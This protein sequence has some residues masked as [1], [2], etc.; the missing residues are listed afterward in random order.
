M[1]NHTSKEEPM[2][3]ARAIRTRRMVR[4]FDGSDL[5]EGVVRSLFDDGLRA[6]TAGNARGVHFVILMGTNETSR[7]FDSATDETWRATARRAPGLQRASAVGVCVVDPSRYVGRYGEADKAPS[8]LGGG[9]DRWPVPYWFGDAGAATMA[10]L[11]R[12]EEEGLAA[13]FLGA[14]RNEAAI[15][16]ALMVP[17][18]FRIYGA[19]LLGRPDGNDVRSPSLDLDGPSRADRLHRAWF[20][21]LQ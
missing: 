13:S 6:P 11:L 21:S 20:G 7:Y 17:G 1:P 5:D 12:A 18:P 9:E 4:S 14:F 2:D 8:G 19:I 16:R 15:K 3:V 10:V